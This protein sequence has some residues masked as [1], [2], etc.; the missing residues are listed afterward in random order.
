MER[1]KRFER[2]LQIQKSIMNVPT[3]K[4]EELKNE[5]GGKP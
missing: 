1:V 3:E 5:K 2:I 4:S